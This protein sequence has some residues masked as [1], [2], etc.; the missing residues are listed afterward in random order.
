[1]AAPRPRPATATLDSAGVARISPSPSPGVGDAASRPSPA[2][3]P[4]GFEVEV[5][6]RSAVLSWNPQ[7]DAVRYHV[8]R[9]TFRKVDFG[10]YLGQGPAVEGQEDPLRPGETRGVFAFPG[11]FEEIGTSTKPVFR[12]PEGSRD[13]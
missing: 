2:P 9:S 8:F 7:P 13:V 11:A 12:L 10:Y 6:N 4:D 3:S 1:M 5:L